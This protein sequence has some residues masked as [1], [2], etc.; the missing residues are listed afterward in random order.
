M[1]RSSCGWTAFLG[2]TELSLCVPSAAA[3][4]ETRPHR[5][6]PHYD[7]KGFVLLESPTLPEEPENAPLNGLVLICS[8]FFAQSKSQSIFSDHAAPSKR[9]CVGCVVVFLQSRPVTLC[10]RWW[11][12]RNGTT[13][14]GCMFSLRVLL[15]GF[16]PGSPGSP[17]P[18]H[19]PSTSM[20][21][22]CVPNKVSTG[23]GCPS[24]LFLVTTRGHRS[25]PPR[26]SGRSG[27]KKTDGWK[28]ERLLV[29]A[30]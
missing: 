13:S 14:S 15:H 2:G 11:S 3:N 1:A 17:A 27:N 25:R 30:S 23:L 21:T 28:E 10:W 24:G 8:E 6:R 5:V 26:P 18:A 19:S 9:C 20:Q 12:S 7:A 22:P 4:D 29:M 16:S